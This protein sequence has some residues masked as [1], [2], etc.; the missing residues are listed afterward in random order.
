[1]R[2]IGL[3]STHFLHGPSLSGVRCPNRLKKWGIFPLFFPIRCCQ[4]VG[5]DQSLLAMRTT[6][7]RLVVATRSALMDGSRFDSLTRS[8]SETV[9]RRHLT[10]FMGMVA[11]GG[12]LSLLGLAEAEA[13]RK[14]KRNRKKRGRTGSPPSP[15]EGQPDDAPCNGTGRCLGGVCNPEPQCIGAGGRA[16]RVGSDCCS[17]T[18][19]EFCAMAAV[20]RQCV[21][22]GD[23]VS[24]RCLGYRCA[25]GTLRNGQSCS[26]DER[27]A[28]GQCGCTEDGANPQCICRRA[29]CG[30][31]GSPCDPANFG[32][33]CCEG[34]CTG[35]VVG[36]GESVCD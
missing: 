21:V 4:I 31:R 8:L 14:K 23:C 2:R 15:C 17:G 11:L 18:C 24:G 22:A 3:A 29:T 25:L 32:V 28:S 26:H 27:C 35:I 9:S 30:G 34:G 36:T 20:G 33:D 7:S 1:M 19:S 10:R 13:K 12:S 5:S 16:C 6:P